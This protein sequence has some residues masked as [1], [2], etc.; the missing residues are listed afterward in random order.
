MSSRGRD[1]D[2]FESLPPSCR[3][4]LQALVALDG[5]ATRQELMCRTGHSSSTMTDALR[6]LETRHWILRTRKSDDLNQVSVEL[7]RSPDL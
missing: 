3:A 7:R 6:T 1:R 4:V 2:D 5:Q